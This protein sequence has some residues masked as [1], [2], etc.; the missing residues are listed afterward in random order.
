MKKAINYIIAGVFWL[1]VLG[2]IVFASMTMGPDDPPK[3]KKET[4]KDTTE[5]DI[6]QMKGINKQMELNNRMLDSL[7]MKLDTIK[8]KK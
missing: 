8:K 1:I 5:I 4:K 6:Q 3:S 7:I 2:W